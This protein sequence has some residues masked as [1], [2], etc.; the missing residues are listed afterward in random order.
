MVPGPPD[1]AHATVAS[2]CIRNCCLDGQEICLGCG[3]HIQEIV[4]WHQADDDERRAILVRAEARRD[5][6][7]GT[8]GE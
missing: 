2:P 1:P 8:G 4:R 3:R 7:H 6:R 5:A